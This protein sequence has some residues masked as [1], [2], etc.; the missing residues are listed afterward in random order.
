MADQTQYSVFGSRAVLQRWLVVCMGQY[1][2][3]YG[4]PHC[5]GLV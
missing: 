4:C 3:L 2:I 5:C 1:A